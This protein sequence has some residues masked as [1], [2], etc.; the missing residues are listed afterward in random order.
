M[1]LG[2]STRNEAADFFSRNKAISA[3]ITAVNGAD[4]NGLGEKATLTYDIW[5]NLPNGPTLYTAVKPITPRPPYDVKIYAVPV[6]TPVLPVFNGS[7]TGFHIPGEW[8]YAK[9]C[10]PPA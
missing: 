10:D 1:M 7:F 6:G 9:E 8:P 5:L 2:I 4:T 3:I